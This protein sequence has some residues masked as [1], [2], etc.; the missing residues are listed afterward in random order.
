MNR[1][2]ISR[3]FAR[4]LFALNTQ[5]NFHETVAVNLSLYFRDNLILFFL[6]SFV[7]ELLN[8]MVE[9]IKYENERE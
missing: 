7:E 1:V 9:Q 4:S 3:S 6:L 8:T 2:I 5:K